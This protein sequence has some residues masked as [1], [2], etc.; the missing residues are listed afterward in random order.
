MGRRSLAVG[1]AMKI[2]CDFL[3]LIKG[4]KCDALYRPIE[5][6]IFNS[7]PLTLMGS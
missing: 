4:E 7:V 5:N 2:T 6:T 1:G 3:V